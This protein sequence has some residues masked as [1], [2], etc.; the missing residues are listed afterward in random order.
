MDSEGS[1]HCDQDLLPPT[2]IGGHQK[3]TFDY[4]I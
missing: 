3:K 2:R 4:L 1:D